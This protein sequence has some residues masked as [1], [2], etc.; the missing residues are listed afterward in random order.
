MKTL[1]SVFIF[2]LLSVS[3]FA[4]CLKCMPP[5]SA[6]PA[7]RAEAMDN[8]LRDWPALHRY[9]DADAID[10]KSDPTGRVVF[11]GN[12][13]TDMWKLAEYFPGKPYLNRGISAQTTAQMLLRFQPDVVDLHPAAVVILAGTNDIAGNNGPYSA[14]ETENN[15]EAMAAIAKANR[16][17]V[18]VCSVIPVNDYTP[19][20][21][22]P[23]AERPM[24]QIR[25]LNDWLKGYA[26]KSGFTYVDYFTA[27]LD[28][29][30]FLKRELAEDGLHP[31]ATGYRI[32]AGIVQKAIDGVL[33][34]KK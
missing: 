22:R 33:R 16:I 12:S 20:S 6:D 25:E 1:T 2:L 10:A 23:F 5:K 7:D 31:N 3:A 28:D 15:F 27:M 29:K 8:W 26:A 11:L 9:A 17:S 18:L 21:K 14:E 34:E 24:S 32:M 30:G 13:I 19:S 4:Q